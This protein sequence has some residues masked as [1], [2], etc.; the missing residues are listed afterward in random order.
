M[1]ASRY[2]AA[3]GVVVV[4]G[5][6]GFVGSHLS[7]RL[8][9]EG[10]TVR[11]I[12]R[13][14]D[15]Y[16]RSDKE[17]NLT[18]LRRETAFSLLEHDLAELS[19][20]ALASLFRGAD[21]IFHQAA[22]PGVRRS[23]DMFE[24]YTQDNIV[25]TQHV[26]EAARQAGVQRVVYA[27]SSSVYGNTAIRPTPETALPQPHSPYGVTKLAAE[28]LA[29]LYRQNYALSTVS[30][31]YFTVYGPRQR[32]DMGFHRFV[33]QALQGERIRLFGDGS[34]T[35]NFTFVA[36]VVEANLAAMRLP[37]NTVS[38]HG[39]VYNVGGGSQVGMREALVLLDQ[40]LREQGQVGLA[41]EAGE[42]Q[43]GDVD[44]TA[45][46]GSRAQAVLGF[47]PK[48]DLAN[49]LRQQIAWH[50]ARRQSAG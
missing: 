28:H 8:V 34:A 33:E 29:E 17:L 50:L 16:A 5:A 3:M 24:V 39:G 12:D 42:P 49:G 48:I 6:A 7:E 35:R 23:W 18:A 44:H 32:P 41:F 25:G 31:R 30:L 1:G 14:S 9:Q 4:T 45:C 10:A 22:Q 43:A 15:Y 13:F 11:G 2:G 19:V 37:A 26:L 20:D 40:L 46:E 27:S 36:D 47:S 38:T 21:C